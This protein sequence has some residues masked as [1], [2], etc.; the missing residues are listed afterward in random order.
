MKPKVKKTP[1]K[2]GP[3]YLKG[4]KSSQTKGLTVSMRLKEQSNPSPP[5]KKNLG[6]KRMNTS[7]KLR[8]LAFKEQP[9]SLQPVLK[10]TTTKRLKATGSKTWVQP[11]CTSKA[12]SA[13][14]PSSQAARDQRSIAIKP[15]FSAITSP[16]PE[17]ET[18]LSRRQILTKG[19]SASSTSVKAHFRNFARESVTFS[20]PHQQL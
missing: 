14:S 12:P 4:T 2:V 15:A 8:L 18:K 6:P 16:K 13:S 17:K 7:E 20:D 9:S 10:K 19:K 1:L 5:Q 11:K 3:S